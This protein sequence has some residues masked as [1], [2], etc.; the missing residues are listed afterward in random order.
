MLSIKNINKA[1]TVDSKDKTILESISLSVDKGEFVSLI[2]PSGSGKSTLFQ[3]IGGTLSADSGQI[4]I[5][6]KMVNGQSGHIA[7]MPQQSTLLPWYTVEKNIQIALE[8]AGISKKDAIPLILEALEQVGLQEYK[9]AYPH[10]L[11]GGMSQRISFIRAL[12]APQQLMLL[13]EPFGALDALT[14][15]NMQKWLLEVW[16]KRKKSV[17]LITH[18]IDEALMLS[19]R[20]YVMSHTPAQVVAEF[21]L[22]FSRPREEKLWTTEQFNKLKDEIYQLLV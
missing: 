15:I 9:D 1:F 7:Y 21:Q 5:D 20:I 11:S 12:L 3:I 10:M 2:G 13:D 8:I 18:S 14:R 4:Q 22:P 19:D 16:G 6:E 17:L